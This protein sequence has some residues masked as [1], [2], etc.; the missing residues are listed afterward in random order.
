[1]HVTFASLGMGG[2]SLDEKRVIAHQLL[3]EVDAECIP[4]G[5]ATR[6]ALFEDLDKREAEADADPNGWRDWDEVYEEVVAKYRNRP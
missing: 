1:M 5:F 3:H 4:G 6:E 2:L